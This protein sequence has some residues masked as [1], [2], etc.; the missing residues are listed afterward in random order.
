MADIMKKIMQLVNSGAISAYIPAFYQLRLIKVGEAQEYDNEY[1]EGH[2]K[3]SPGDP[4]LE[5]TRGEHWSP[6]WKKI[7]KKYQMP[8]GAGIDSEKIPVDQWI[9]I[10]T[11]PEREK[12]RGS[13]TWAVDAS[14]VST[15]PFKVG[16]LTIDPAVDMLCM[17]GDEIHPNPEGGCWP[18]K[19]DIFQDT[20]EPLNG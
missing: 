2:Y 9:T 13:I 16:K 12:R 18:V 14:L 11:H 19:K 17:G 4:K 7:L 6:E 15:E 3:L 5:G 10:Q 20:Y 8:N 1:G